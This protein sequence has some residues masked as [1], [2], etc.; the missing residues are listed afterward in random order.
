MHYFGSKYRQ[1]K[2][3]ETEK[4]SK[5]ENK[6]EK[7]LKQENKEESKQEQTRLQTWLEIW[8]WLQKWKRNLETERFIIFVRFGYAVVFAAVF[9][10]AIANLSDVISLLLSVVDFFVIVA[11]VIWVGLTEILSALFNIGTTAVV[12]AFVSGVTLLGALILIKL[13]CN[14]TSAVH[15]VPAESM[16]ENLI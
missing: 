10:L 7:K 2:E 13:C 5:R 11:A 9:A 15:T 14:L 1:S 12:V 6:E 8:K 4:K 3:S 16:L